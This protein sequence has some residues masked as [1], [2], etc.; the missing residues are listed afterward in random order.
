MIRVTDLSKSYGGH[1]AI[2]GL[3]FTVEKGKIYGFLGPNGAGKS[4]TMNIMTGCLAS[5]SGEVLIGGHDIVKEAL[6]AKKLIGYLPEQP[7]LYPEMTVE[8]YLGFVAEMKGLHGAEKAAQ[9]AEVMAK[10]SV[11]DVS[12]RLIRNLSKGYKQRIGVAQ[13]ILGKP[14]LIILD[15]PT[16]GLDPKQIMEI[17]ELIRS[18][19]P[20]HTV[21]LSSHIL[22]EVR[23]VCDRIIIISAGRLVA[24]DTPENLEHLFAGNQG[25]ELKVKACCR[26][27][28]EIIECMPAVQRLQ[29]EMEENGICR[30]S[31]LSSEDIAEEIFFTFAEHRL[32]IVSMIPSHASL[33]D[34]YLELTAVE[35]GGEQ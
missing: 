4:T 19:A 7:P 8:E 31:L 10:T 30:V 6:E 28:Q 23:A 34:V 22:S 24:E 29:C 11:A 26:Q 13:A 14:A 3:S 25:L 32:P 27:V 15:E 21:L 9:I 17:R 18:L 1:R 12:R 20:E 5:D 16:V 35:K 2:T 33:E